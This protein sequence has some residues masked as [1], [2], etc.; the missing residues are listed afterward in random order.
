MNMPEFR[1]LVEMGDAQEIVDLY[2]SMAQ[3]RHASTIIPGRLGRALAML[4]DV[5]GAR[6]AAKKLS[7]REVG[8]AHYDALEIE[9][10]AALADH[11]PKTRS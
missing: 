6:E 8:M 10:Q 7:E 2:R 3:G 5:K 9:A 1:L 11:D 4:G